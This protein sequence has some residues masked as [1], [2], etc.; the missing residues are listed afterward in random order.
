MLSLCKTNNEVKLSLEEQVTLVQQGD[1]ELQQTL[2]TNYQPFIAKVVSH[3]CK[4]YINPKK[5][6][7]FSIGL[8]AFY[9]AMIGYSINK[10]TSFLSFASL[11]IKRKTIDYLRKENRKA[12]WIPLDDFFDSE[13]MECRVER[14][15]AKEN[16]QNEEEQWR[17]R[18][19]INQF[20]DALS[21]YDITL[22][23]LVKISPKHSDARESAIQVAHILYR[24][25]SLRE[26]VMDK[27]KIPM[28]KLVPLVPVSKKTLERN[29]K[30]ILAV[31]IVLCGDYLY[32]KE[33]LNKA[34]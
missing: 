16:Y 8:Y 9:E 25:P 2:L 14:V 33:Y 26:Y 4:R 11:V 21:L 17:Q 13:E 20:C 3:V 19:E 23:E 22:E 7:E 28:N 27:K 15:V 6:D 10:G 29:R 1:Q 24:E 32:L 18:E 30:Y 34:S 31:F 12:V 5:D